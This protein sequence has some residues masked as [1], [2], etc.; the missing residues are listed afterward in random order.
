MEPSS[1]F[2]KAKL[3]WTLRGQ[4]GMEISSCWAPHRWDNATSWFR[5]PPVWEIPESFTF[6]GW[7][8]GGKASL[9]A[10]QQPREAGRGV[11]ALGAGE[12][13]Y[14][15]K[16]LWTHSAPSTF[17][18]G[19]MGSNTA[20]ICCKNSHSQCK[21]QGECRR[22]WLLWDTQFPAPRELGLLSCVPKLNPNSTTWGLHVFA[23]SSKSRYKN[24]QK[25]PCSPQKNQMPKT[26]PK[27]P[28]KLEN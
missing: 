7:F 21:G 5:I 25:H 1:G 4:H 8:W 10:E 15:W 19:I 20:K 13:F 11:P 22:G 18:A 16:N 9:E 14:A 27:K 3:G 26:H 24:I 17:P 12:T 28:S 6:A 23:S 2:L